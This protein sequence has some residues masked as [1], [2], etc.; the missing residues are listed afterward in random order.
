MQ[1][2]CVC[3]D[4]LCGILFGLPDAAKMNLKH[5]D[6]KRPIKKPFKIISNFEVYLREIGEGFQGFF[7]VFI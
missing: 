6:K 3:L 5:V 2:L 7:K 1:Q 4:V